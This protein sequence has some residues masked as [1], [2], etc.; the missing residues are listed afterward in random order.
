MQQ[1]PNYIDENINIAWYICEDHVSPLTYKLPKGKIDE[2]HGRYE[3]MSRI[4]TQLYILSKNVTVVGACGVNVMGVG[5]E[6]P[7]VMKF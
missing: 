6:N 2:Y 5:C 4:M 1:Q 3:N 7:K